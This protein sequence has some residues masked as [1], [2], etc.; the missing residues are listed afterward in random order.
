[1]HIFKHL[2]TFKSNGSSGVDIPHTIFIFF[3]YRPMHANARQCWKPTN[4]MQGMKIEQRTTA[5]NLLHIRHTDTHTHTNTKNNQNV[6][7]IITQQHFH[8]HYSASSQI[9]DILTKAGKGLAILCINKMRNTALTKNCREGN[10]NGK[11]GTAAPVRFLFLHTYEF[12]T[13]AA[14]CTHTHAIVRAGEI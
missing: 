8:L 10:I 12:N 3:L 13:I 5:H 1:M 6:Y 11:E 4:K 14:G 2:L 9:V 7:Y